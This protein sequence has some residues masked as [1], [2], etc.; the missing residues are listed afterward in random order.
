VDSI[1]IVTPDDVSVLR[2]RGHPSLTLVTC[3]PFYFVGSAPD[4][5]IVQASLITQN[6]SRPRIQSP[7][8]ITTKEEARE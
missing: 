1:R 7:K 4:R 6:K 5:Y 3:Y 8:S 2:A